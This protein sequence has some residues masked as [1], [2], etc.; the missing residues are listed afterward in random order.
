M[1]YEK[2][3]FILHKCQTH[4][5]IIITCHVLFITAVS[6]TQFNKGLN[7][8]QLLEAIGFT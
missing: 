6:P 2:N 5:L 4:K 7:S 8:G 3:L 1:C